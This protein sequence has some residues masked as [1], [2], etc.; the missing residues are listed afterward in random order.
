MVQ[1]M[2]SGSSPVQLWADVRTDVRTGEAPAHH[3]LGRSESHVL[4]RVEGLMLVHATRSDAH[5]R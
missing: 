5:Q 3:R 2:Q 1:R 4:A